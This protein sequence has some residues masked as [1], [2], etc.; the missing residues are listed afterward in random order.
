MR[1][2]NPL[3]WGCETILHGRALAALAIAWVTT[4][5]HT[6]NFKEMDG[7]MGWISA[8]GYSL[9]SALLLSIAFGFILTKKV[10]P[11]FPPLF[12]TRIGLIGLATGSFINGGLIHAPYSI[13]IAGRII[14]GLGTGFVLFSTP[15]MIPPYLKNQGAW[16]GIVIPAFAPGIVG[17]ATFMYG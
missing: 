9:H 6:M 14:A 12:L 16:A 15:S 11:L 1:I 13:C 7:A 17:T 8:Q 5:G 2:L 10:G 3:L 4:A